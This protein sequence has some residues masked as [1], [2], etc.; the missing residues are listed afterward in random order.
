MH[1]ATPDATTPKGLLARVV[2]ILFSPRETY[3]DVSLRPRPL[4]ILAVVLAIIAAANYTFLR[5]EVG[6]RA[7]M[8]QA[9]TQT[10]AYGRQPTPQM[11]EGLER[12][13]PYAAPIAAAGTL[14][15]VPIVMAALAGLFVLVFNAILGGDATFKQVFAIVAHSGVI[16]AVQQLFVTPLNYARESMGSPASVGMLLPMIDSGSF[17][18]MLLGAVDL[19]QVWSLISISIGLGVLYKR[20][21]SPIGWSLLATA[22]VIVLI[23]TG[24]KAARSGA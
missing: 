23:L 12:M 14:V 11:I 17:L 15:A 6:Q 7:W 20:R 24:I 5:T 4:A 3:A 16:G 18:G 8:D 10:E 21:T 1:T 22:F 9:L 19:F 2:G 13:K